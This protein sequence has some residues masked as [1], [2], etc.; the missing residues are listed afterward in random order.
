MGNWGYIRE[1]KE[2]GK[3]YLTQPANQLNKP[4]LPRCVSEVK[5]KVIYEVMYEVMHEGSTE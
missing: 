3:I 1:G 4:R 2:K 5:C